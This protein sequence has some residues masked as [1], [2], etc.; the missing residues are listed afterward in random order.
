MFSVNSLF[1]WYCFLLSEY[2]LIQF[3]VGCVV[4]NFVFN[5]VFSVQRVFYFFHCRIEVRVFCGIVLFSNFVSFFS[6][7]VVLYVFCFRDYLFPYGCCHCISHCYIF[8]SFLV[9]VNLLQEFSDQFF[10]RTGVF[11]CSIKHLFNQLR[12]I[13]VLIWLST[14]L[15]KY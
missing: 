1:W 8:I 13:V 7:T 14:C 4:V 9:V 15:G 3:L 2:L 12:K 6:M 11:T 5:D 10:V